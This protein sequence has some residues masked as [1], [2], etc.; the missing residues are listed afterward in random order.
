[1]CD[2][3]GAMSDHDALLA[4]VL[5]RPE[6]DTPRLILADWLDD[7]MT[8]VATARAEFI[9]IQ[10]ELARGKASPT[11]EDWLARRTLLRR[12]RKF[13][14]L[15]DE[16][17]APVVRRFDGV[18]VARGF[19]ERVR[20]PM[21]AFLE[22]AAELFAAHPVTEVVIYD[23]RPYFQPPP[24]ANPVPQPVEWDACWLDNQEPGLAW[25]LP[26]PIF[27]LLPERYFAFEQYDD[28][29]TPEDAANAALSVA[30][31]QYGR[32]LGRR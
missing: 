21:S 28:A 7:Q 25:H 17:F 12:E 5:D 10:V 22:H 13:T 26:K 24:Y 15:R 11:H 30:C 32:Q 8:P 9:R 14:P 3:G 6:D 31:I 4:A 29:E 27:R 19:V 20:T 1:M 2:L 16:W 18:T 23:R